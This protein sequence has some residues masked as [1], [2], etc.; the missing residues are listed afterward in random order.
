MRVREC[1]RCRRARRGWRRRQ[2][3]DA[4]R[5]WGD[6]A[7]DVG[8]DAGDVVGVQR[9]PLA[10]GFEG[11]RAAEGD[12][13]LL[14]AELLRGVWRTSGRLS[15]PP[16]GRARDSPFAPGAR[17]MIEIPKEL[18]P[19]PAA[20]LWNLIPSKNP[21]IASMSSTFVWVT[22]PSGDATRAQVPQM[23]L[24]DRIVSSPSYDRC[25]GREADDCASGHGRV[26]R[27]GRAAAAAGVEG[28]AGGCLR[29]GAAG[30]GDDGELRGSQAGRDPLGD[31]GGGRA[32]AAARR[33]LPAAG[34]H[35]L[36]GGVGRR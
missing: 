25:D 17:S 9:V 20:A 22:S 19:S 31:A 2:E 16:S 27:V 34:L 28:E 5:A 36:P 12:V 26:L 7:L 6:L 24:A 29:V 32:A 18:T 15:P 11:A 4:L 33:R 13:D 14:L 21:S 8:A 10:V 30:G 1:R 3:A 23:S 35:R